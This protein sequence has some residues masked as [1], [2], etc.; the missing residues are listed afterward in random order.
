MS[1]CYYVFIVKHKYSKEFYIG[2]RHGLRI[3]PELDSSYIGSGVW[4]AQFNALSRRFLEKT[5]LLVFSSRK[6]ARKFEQ[7][8]IHINRRNPL[9]GNLGGHDRKRQEVYNR[10]QRIIDLWRSGMSCRDIYES[11]T[12]EGY[13]YGTI[14]QICSRAADGRPLLTSPDYSDERQS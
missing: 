8:L 2:C 1:D 5:V 14:S 4:P 11:Q 3:R 7:I 9:C 13:N 12:D 10:H 6:S